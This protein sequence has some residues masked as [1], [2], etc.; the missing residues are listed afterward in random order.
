MNTMIKALSS[1][2]LDRVG[3]NLEAEI[4]PGGGMG[5]FHLIF[6]APETP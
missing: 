1:G 2:A 3:A 4:S 6:L 5:F